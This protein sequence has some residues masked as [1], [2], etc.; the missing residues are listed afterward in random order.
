MLLVM[1][2]LLNNL[3]IRFIVQ[4]LYRSFIFNSLADA[5]NLFKFVLYD[6]CV[7]YLKALSG[8]L[9][10]LCNVDWLAFSYNRIPYCNLLFTRV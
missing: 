9:F 5:Y 3:N 7:T 4:N 2:L 1:S 6:S 10:K 8:T